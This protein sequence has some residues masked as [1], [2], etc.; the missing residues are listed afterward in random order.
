MFKWV[1]SCD[2]NIPVTFKICTLEGTLPRVSYEDLIDNPHLKYGGRMQGKYPDLKVEAVIM[3]DNVPLH[4]PVRAAYK[5]MTNR[6]EWN[7][8]LTLPLKYSD[9]PRDANLCINI[10]DC[11]GPGN[12]PDFCVGG[13]TISLFGSKSPLFRT[14]AIDLCVHNGTPADGSKNSK[15]P[16]KSSVGKE[17]LERLAKLG[18][19]YHE[20]KLPHVDW[21]DRLTFAEVEKINKVEKSSSKLLFLMIEFTQ[22]K[23]NGEPISLVYFEKN[24]DYTNEIPVPSDVIRVTDPMINQEN[25]VEAKFHKLA[26]SQRAGQMA[27]EMKPNAEI[28]NR[29]QEII[30][31]PSTQQITSEETDMI[32]NYR[33]YLSANKHALSKFVRCINWKSKEEAQQAMDFINNHWAAMDVD[34]ALE[35]LGPSFRHPGLRQYAVQRLRQAPD[36]ALSLYLLQLVQALKYEKISDAWLNPTAAVIAAELDLSD[37]SL[38]S[39]PPAVDMVSSGEDLLPPA[40]MMKVDKSLTDSDMLQRS[41]FSTSGSNVGDDGGLAGFLI[42]R[43]CN[44]SAIAN[45]FYWYLTIE[46]E[47]QQAGEILREDKKQKEMYR[48]VLRRFKETLRRGSPE[49]KERYGFLSRQNHFMDK[50][51]QLIK[52]V[53]RESGNRTKKIERL[54][55][56]LADPEA[57][58]F[59]F[60]KFEALQLPLDPDIKV[61]GL[62]PS[63]ATLFKSSLMPARLSFVTTEGKEYVTLFKHGDDLRQDQL[64]L[65]IITLMDS[66]LQQ[67]NLD[68]KLTPYRV[69]ATSSK[70]GFVQ[71]VDSQAIASVLKTD[72]SILNF[73]RKHNP[74]ETGP[75]GVAADVIDTYV[76]SCAGYC[77]ITYILGVGDRHLDNLLLTKQGH[78][79]H[80]DF[81]YILGRD[82]KVLPPPMK[83][84][85]EMLEAFG[86]TGPGSEYYQQFIKECYTAYLSLRRSSSLIINLF[87]LMVDASVPD[88]ALEPDKTVKKVQDKFRLDL[89]DEEAVKWL[90]TTVEMSSG[91]MAA[92]IAERIHEWAQ[93]M[94]N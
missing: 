33:Y 54:Q 29:L 56:L 25:L 10:Y 24:G 80:I 31:L 49:M 15:T 55:E 61:C 90:L 21:L 53:D 17:N 52:A 41:T 87:S 73:F 34:D 85:R 40:A 68:L 7:E 74:S 26:R 93:F 23:F 72:K 59:N 82:P 14:G 78:L 13:T 58:K 86:G 66:I 45:Y 27:S 83:L 92:A 36:S 81:G 46:T 2:V 67:E 79:F 1:R 77:V 51:F 30:R 57:F 39:S 22:M 48:S 84:S 4:V 71:Y 9:L 32:W 38:S 35:L 63:K 44:N 20:G 47:E 62:I 6:W 3:L 28:R 91:A 37:S 70:H 16:G 69:L 88:I 12:H 94:R 50:L 75:F 43:A 65:Q 19:Q 11:N 8:W 42:D 64:I 5:H 89:T 60:T 76:K 18:K